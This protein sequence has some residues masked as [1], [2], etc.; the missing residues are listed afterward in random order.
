VEAAC[1]VTGELT[2]EPLTGEQTFTPAELGALHDEVLVTVAVT[3][4]NHFVP[5]VFTA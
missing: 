1:T 4:F 3:V 5:A 2:V